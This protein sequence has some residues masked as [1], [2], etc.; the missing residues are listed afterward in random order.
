MTLG[1]E[2]FLKM[3]SFMINEEL[4]VYSIKEYELPIYSKKS[5]AGNIVVL[6]EIDLENFFNEDEEITFREALK[7]DGFIFD[8]D[9]EDYFFKEADLVDFET[10]NFYIGNSVDSSINIYKLGDLYVKEEE[11][12]R[13][14]YED[15]NTLLDPIQNYYI[16][17]ECSEETKKIY[18]H[19]SEDIKKI[20][21]NKNANSEE[22]MSIKIYDFIDITDLSS[23]IN[24]S[25]TEIG[26]DEN[27]DFWIWEINNCNT[28]YSDDIKG[29]MFPLDKLED[30]QFL[31]EHYLSYYNMRELKEY[32]MA[33]S[34]E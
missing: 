5:E 26:K 7:E 23:N 1:M 32:M 11:G 21:L 29:E 20:I 27:G 12:S 28:T 19:D 10:I 18:F 17:R 15:L 34:H 3:S 24:S 9:D 6:N 22:E 25:F 16:F 31:N 14:V 2:K 4:E 13:Y 30:L 8:G 33:G